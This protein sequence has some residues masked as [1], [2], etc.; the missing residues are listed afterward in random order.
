MARASWRVGLWG[1]VCALGLSCGDNQQFPI[2]TGT[3]Q[4]TVL[5]PTG[6]DFVAA[7]GAAVS[8]ARPGGGRVE[9]VADAAGQVTFTKLAWSAGTAG[10]TAYI[11]D[12]ALQSR[13]GILEADGPVTLR[14]QLP[15]DG[16]GSVKLWGEAVLADNAHMLRVSTPHSSWQKQGPSWSLRVPRNTPCPIVAVEWGGPEA[17]APEGSIQRFFGWQLIQHPG[18]AEDQELLIDFSNKLTPKTVQGSL[19]LPSGFDARSY[20]QV[21]GSDAGGTVFGPSIGYATR[22]QPTADG[23]RLEHDVEYVEVP[24]LSRVVTGYKLSSSAGESWVLVEGYPQGGAHDLAFLSIPRSV[25]P[26]AVPRSLYSPLSWTPAPDP[27]LQ[28]S[29]HLAPAGSGFNPVVWFVDMP[30]GATGATVPPPPLAA[31]SEGVVGTVPLEA[32]LWAG[33]ASLTEFPARATSTI[34]PLLQP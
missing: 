2:G 24:G 23:T 33:K 1:L 4:V 34:L 19:A 12:H 5:R 11:P 25:A 14:L 8:L 29:I 13:V 3:L 21:S 16:A 7:A 27:S 9:L 31:L 20:V 15:I 32:R 10:V 30:P 22:S 18:A 17:S 26:V 6:V 28:P